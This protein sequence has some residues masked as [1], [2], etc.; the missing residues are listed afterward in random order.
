[1]AGIEVMGGS[2]AQRRRVNCWSR[3]T[4]RASLDEAGWTIGRRSINRARSDKGQACRRPR[5]RPYPRGSLQRKVQSRTEYASRTITLAML[6]Q[7]RGIGAFNGAPERE[8]VLARK[9]IGDDGSHSTG[10]VH[11]RQ[12]MRDTS[13]RLQVTDQ[14]P[15]FRGDVTGLRLGEV[16]VTG[17]GS[18]VP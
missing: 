15:T 11:R 6:A 16:G 1:M 12:Y 4:T 7:S 9:C 2:R 5:P 10:I 13:P 3:E 8:V 17:S 18:W 14:C